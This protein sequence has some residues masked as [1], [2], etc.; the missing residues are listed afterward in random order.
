MKKFVVLAAAAFAAAPAFAAELGVLKPLPGPEPYYSY[1]K[2]PPRPVFTW[3]GCY[4]GGHVG[5]ALA[6]NDFTDG[7]FVALIPP[8]SVTVPP[9]PPTPF[10]ISDMSFHVNSSGA[11]VGG[12]AGCNYQFAPSGFVI[13][14]EVDAAWTRMTG[15]I[16]ESSLPSTPPVSNGATTVSS[17]GTVFA[18]NDFLATATARF[19][20]AVGYD[21]QGLIYGKAGAAWTVDKNHFAG[22]L[23]ATTCIANADPTKPCTPTTTG[24]APFDYVAAAETRLGWTIGAG[25]E[26]SMLGN[27]SLKG[28]YNYMNFGR[29]TATF[30]N[31]S[32]AVVNGPTFPATNIGFGQQ[33]SEVKL[34]INYLFGSRPYPGLY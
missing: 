22:G 17:S 4:L 31:T 10:T 1:Y 7:P 16:V 24:F 5:G 9:T 29:H 32:V 2:V 3:T 19:G 34:G 28:E 8:P 27:W 23:T 26:W 13:G 18:L 30:T 6:N 12:Q 20:Y 33:I 15:S 14:V 25:V 21:N 11:L